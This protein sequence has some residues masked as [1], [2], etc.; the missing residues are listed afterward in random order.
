MKYHKKILLEVSGHDHISDLR[1]NNGSTIVESGNVIIKSKTH[2]F[3]LHNILIAPGVTAA[4]GQNPG[5]ALFDLNER[6]GSIFAENLNMVFLP[7]L[8]TYNWYEI[9]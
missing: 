7:L 6:Q 4:S 9:P 5:Y 8:K 3:N 1:Y 2:D